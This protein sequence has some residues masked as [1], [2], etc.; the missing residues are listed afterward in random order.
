MLINY[1]NNLFLISLQESVRE[2]RH[3]VHFYMN[4]L[5]RHLDPQLRMKNPPKKLLKG[6]ISIESLL[7]SLEVDLRSNPNA[8]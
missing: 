2:G 7:T 8:T 1:F 5:C 3:S 4:Q 6:L